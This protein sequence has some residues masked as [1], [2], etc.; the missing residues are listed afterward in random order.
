[1]TGRQVLLTVAGLV[2]AAAILMT[3]GFAAARIFGGAL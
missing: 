1:M 2:I 3:I